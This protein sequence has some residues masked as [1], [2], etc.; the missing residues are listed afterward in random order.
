MNAMISMG[1]LGGRSEG[2][3]YGKD[4]EESHEEG[5]SQFFALNLKV[6]IGRAHV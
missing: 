2:G 6:E 3:D 1:H 4:D 5:R